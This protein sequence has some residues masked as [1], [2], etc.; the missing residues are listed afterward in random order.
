MNDSKRDLLTNTYLQLLVESHYRIAIQNGRRVALQVCIF[1]LLLFFK[2]EIASPPLMVFAYL[3]SSNNN[4]DDDNDKKK[5]GKENTATILQLRNNTDPFHQLYDRS[6]T[7][8]FCHPFLFKYSCSSLNSLSPLW[9]AGWPADPMDRNHC[10]PW[11]ST[12]S[13]SR[14]VFLQPRATE[15]R[16]PLNLLHSYPKIMKF[17]HHKTAN[18]LPAR[19]YQKLRGMFWCIRF[20][21]NNRNTLMS[22]LYVVLQQFLQNKSF[23]KVSTYRILFKLFR[24]FLIEL[25]H[26]IFMY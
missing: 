25:S 17:S 4:N 19:D 20:G 14:E 6:I 3:M 24:I 11:L 1:T 23:P 12:N 5:R 2:Q 9:G 15:E 13:L 22:T 18:S 26:I 10:K 8:C 21:W 16:R 7:F